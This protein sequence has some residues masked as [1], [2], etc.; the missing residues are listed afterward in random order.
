MC[1]DPL[2]TC[3]IQFLGIGIL[4]SLLRVTLKRR[5]ELLA[6]TFAQI[7]ETSIFGAKCSSN[8][9]FF[10]QIHNQRFKIS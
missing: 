6:D 7:T 4:E 8:F 5:E 9:K 10:V 2:L 3:T 1:W